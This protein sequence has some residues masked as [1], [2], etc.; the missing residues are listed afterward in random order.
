MKWLTTTEGFVQGL[1]SSEDEPLRMADYQLRF[2]KDSSKFRAV[3]KSRGV[4]F[5]FVCA[6]E[7]L[8]KAHLGKNYTAIFV[9]MNLEEAIEKIRYA[10]LL[11]ESLPLKWRRKKV[12]DNKTSIEFEDPT[13]RFRSRLL[14]HPCKD[15]R[16]KHNADVFLDE[17]AHYG[18]KSRSIYVAAVPTVSRGGG[19]LT[20]GSTPL[21]VG[22]LFCDI[23]KEEHRK[24][25]MFTRQSLPW[26]ACPDFCT[27]LARARNEAPKM[28]SDARVHAFG[29]PTLVDI[30]HT[31]ERDDFQQEYELSFNDESQTYFPYDLIF[32]CCQDEMEIS[33]SIAKIVSGTKGD[34]FAGFDVGRT[35]NTSELII[36][37][38]KPKRL[39][40]RMGRSFDRSRFQ[41][42]EAFLKEMMKSSPRFRRL[43]ID[44][45]GIGMNLA[46]NLRTEFRSRVE[47]VAMLGQMKESLAVGLKI[48]FENEGIAI[49]RDRDLTG[50]VHSIK[51]S[52]TGAGYARFDTETNEKHHA[53]KC[54]ALALAVHASG[55]LKKPRRKRDGISA[56][57]V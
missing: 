54:W 36:L 26:W 40:Y 19:Q 11:F 45:H 55:A 29:Q 1:M 13:G 17:F 35:R 44:R 2:L 50:Q 18:A 56:S 6:A 34:L 4:G 22:D 53:D 24:Y 9:S 12:V 30:F 37:E 41:V 43:C 42:Q 39:V 7:A 52:S 15:P 10:N 32:S 47:A 20:I 51:K 8:A 5:S 46:E 28:E 14:S 21:T 49:P 48:A 31:M 23:M 27:D 25:P 33:H 57:I 38:R 3:G 16:G